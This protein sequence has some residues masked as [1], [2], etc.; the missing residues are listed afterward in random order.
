MENT[1][2]NNRNIWI[3]VGIIILVAI[4]YFASKNSTTQNQSTINNTADE[5]QTCAKSSKDLYDSLVKK[6]ISQSPNS[7]AI[8]DF[9][10]MQSQN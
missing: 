1:N 7:T 9:A 5:S 4:F 8:V 10:S 6:Y 2:K 3:V